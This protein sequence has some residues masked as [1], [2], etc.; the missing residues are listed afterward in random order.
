MVN[1]DGQGSGRIDKAVPV[2]ITNTMTANTTETTLVTPTVSVVTTTA[3][4]NATSIKT[5]AGTLYCLNVTN[6]T[7][8]TIYVK[9]YNK[10][11]APTVGTDVPVMTIPV[12]A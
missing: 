7:A 10:A 1:I 12:A 2:H 11:S 6:K 8:A 5:T 9:L 4:T 3:S